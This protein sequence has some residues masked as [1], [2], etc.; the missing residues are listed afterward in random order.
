MRKVA[1]SALIAALYCGL[2]I[3]LAPISYGPLQFR[4]AEAMTL[5]PFIMPEAV[6]GL[7]VGCALSNFFGGFGLIDVILGSAAT[8]V[9]AWLTRRMPSLWLAAIP[10]TAVNAIVVGGYLAIL[11]E[12]PLILSMSYIA[13]SQGVICFGLGIPLCKFAEKSGIVGNTGD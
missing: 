2:T 7:F 4:I 10:P 13:L 8:L 1:L 6:L 5:L 11:T 3:A 9:A 12:T